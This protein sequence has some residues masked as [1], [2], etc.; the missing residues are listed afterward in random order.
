MKIIGLTGPSG[1]GKSTV[2]QMAKDLGFYVIDCDK[3]SKAVSQNISVLKKIEKA[4]PGTVSGTTLDRKKL[5]QKAFSDS[6]STELLNG[7]MLPE[8]NKEIEKE[9]ASAQK[10]GFNL[11][12]LDAPTL[13]ES[14][15]DKKC[16]AVI[17]VLSDENLRKE[18]LV[19]RDGLTN[20]QLKARLNAAKSN[21]FY[22]EKTPYIIYNNGEL[23]K[24]TDDTLK[25]LKQLICE[26]R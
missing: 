5:A 22:I 20:E 23:N 21:S 17:A 12:L 6:K 9:I 24:Y 19:L 25:L 26:M 8:I 11:I 10:N 15:F 13:F 3:T 4:F 18:R 14:G 2:A 1:V 7:I 16:I